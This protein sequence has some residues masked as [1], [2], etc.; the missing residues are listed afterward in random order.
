MIFEEYIQ[1]KNCKKN[2]IWEIQEK[3]IFIVI[4]E[5][6]FQKGNETQL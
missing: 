4:R 3:D 5:E 2:E 6:K 1:K